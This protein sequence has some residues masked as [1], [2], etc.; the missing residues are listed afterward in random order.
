MANIN[1]ERNSF[2][3][4]LNTIYIIIKKIYQAYRSSLNLLFYIK[5][6]KIYNKNL[7]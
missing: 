2:F 7:S 4:K 3:I 6:M 1:K 5:K